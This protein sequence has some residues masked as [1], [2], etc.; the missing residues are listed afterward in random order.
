MPDDVIVY[1][2]HG[3]G[4]AC[5]KNIGKE[6]WSTIGNQKQNNYY[7]LETDKAKFVQVLTSG[8]ATP[9]AYFFEDARI[10]KQG[11][12]NVD[13]VIAR[14][15]QALSVAAFK[16]LMQQDVLILDTR[17]AATFE[18][19]FI[20]GSLNIGLNGQ[21]A[22]WAGTLIPITQ[23]LILV[24]DAGAET[25]SVLRLARV[26]F[27]NVLGV[28]SGGINAWV[29]AGKPVEK[30]KTITPQ[31]LKEIAATQHIIDVRKP[32][33]WEQG[34]VQH[35]QLISL[36]ELGVKLES[37]DT[38]MPYAIHCAGGYRSM[39]AASMMHAKGF[40]NI[41]NVDGGY[42]KIKE[43]GITLTTPIVVS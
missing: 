1:P 32:G 8:L 3:P 35:A 5:G 31:T 34:V 27:E 23:K 13:E 9:P 25:E 38:S 43:T 2:A 12:N 18:Q 21:F 29:K 6:T 10:N 20:K 22:V 41:V 19:A 26:G 28:L 33:E 39:I 11:Y 4:S 40:Y 42:A 7:M 17:P 37:L 24:T 36:N 14:N 16:T 30:I 15:S